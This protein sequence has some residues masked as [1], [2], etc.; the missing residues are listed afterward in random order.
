MII[1]SDTFFLSRMT[2]IAEL[3][4][5]Y[6]LPA[7]AP[8]REFASHGGLVSY[9]ANIP[10]V[11]RLT[12]VYTARV[13]KGTKPHDLPVLQP[14]TFDLVINLKTAKAL[15]LEVPPIAARPRRRGDRVGSLYAAMLSLAHLYGPAVRCKSDMTAWR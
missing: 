8:Y 7:L 6:K 14:T 1:V 13:L 5:Q 9:G 10:D 12:G 2:R 15:G 3:A 11:Y 4:A